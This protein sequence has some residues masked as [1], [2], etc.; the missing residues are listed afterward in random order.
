MGI[1]KLWGWEEDVEGDIRVHKDGVT[2]KPTVFVE[3]L[4]VQGRDYYCVS[5]SW[6]GKLT[7]TILLDP[8][9]ASPFPRRGLIGEWQAYSN[10]LQEWVCAARSWDI[11]I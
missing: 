9:L 10:I 2:I 5:S 7:I 8:P 1:V 6:F 11:R 4:L 3:S